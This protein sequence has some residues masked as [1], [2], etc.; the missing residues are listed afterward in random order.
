[1]IGLDRRAGMLGTIRIL[2][3]RAD[4]ARLRAAPFYLMHGVV[5]IPLMIGITALRRP[6]T[7]EV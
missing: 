5:E 4:S 6:K 1:M 7:G 3:R 2:E